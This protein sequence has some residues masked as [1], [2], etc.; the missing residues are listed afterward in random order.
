[1]IMETRTRLATLPLAETHSQTMV[2]KFLDSI[3][4]NSQQSKRIYGFG[5]SHFQGFL[6]NEYGSDCSIDSIID[7]LTINKINVYTLLDILCMK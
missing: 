2:T 5:L 1:M 4:R 6:Y 3:G 7:S